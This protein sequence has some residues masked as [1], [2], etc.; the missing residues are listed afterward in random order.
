MGAELRKEGRFSLCVCFS[1]HDIM[2]P[3]CLIFSLSISCGQMFAKKQTK[4]IL[5]DFQNL[6][7]SIE[8]NFQLYIDTLYNFQLYIDTLYDLALL[9]WFT[10]QLGCESSLLYYLGTVVISG[11]GSRKEWVIEIVKTKSLAYV[12]FS[13]YELNFGKLHSK[14]VPRYL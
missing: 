4:C 1:F 12:I 8:C 14:L 3:S 11:V 13:S 7:L 2:L 6:K 10:C 9:K 5:Q